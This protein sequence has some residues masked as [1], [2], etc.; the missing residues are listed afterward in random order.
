MLG[1]GGIAVAAPARLG[2]G[3]IADRS[4]AVL[5]GGGRTE[6]ETATGGGGGITEQSSAV[7]GGGGI[8]EH[9]TSSASNS[10]PLCCAPPAFPSR[11]PASTN[12]PTDKAPHRQSNRPPEQPA[13]A[14]LS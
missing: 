1:G 12:H 13:E 14:S 4:C 9:D 10:I 3:G 5:G 8:T 7:L 2:G 11:S 6:R